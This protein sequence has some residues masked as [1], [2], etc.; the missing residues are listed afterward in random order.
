M[1]MRLARNCSRRWISPFKRECSGIFPASDRCLRPTHYGLMQLTQPLSQQHKIGL[2]I[3]LAQLAK[4]A[5]QQKLA[6]Q[7]QSTANQ[8][9]KAYYAILQTQSSLASSEENLKFDRELDRTTDQLVAQKAALKSD[10]MSVKA[11][12][13]QE[14][15]TG[16]TLRNTLASQKE[17]LNNLMGRDIRTDF[18]VV[19]VSEAT[20][21]EGILE[22]AQAKALSARPELREGRLRVQQAELNRRIT[23]AG[24][25]PDVSL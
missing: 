8:V 18:S 6:S 3:R 23:K 7:K 13:A 21:V 20:G 1:F 10:S 9:K 4:A 16:L 2:N 25:I 17:Q 11:R 12:L 19:E 15:Y 14:E 5:D 22:E 24:Y